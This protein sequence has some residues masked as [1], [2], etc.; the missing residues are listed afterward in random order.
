[1]PELKYLF[2]GSP[3]LAAT[4]LEAL[5]TRL[6]EPLAVVTQVAKAAGRGQKIQPTAVETYAKTQGLTVFSSLNVNHAHTMEILKTFQPDVILVAA[7]GQILKKEL[8]TLPRLFCLNVHASLLPKYRGAAPIQWAIWNGETETGITVQK[9]AQKLDT[10]DILLQHR[11]HI[12]PDETS[13]RLMDRLAVLGGECL[14]EAMQKIEAG[15]YAFTP[16]EESQATY[17]A[18]IEKAQAA[19]DWTQP[20][21]RLANQLRALQPWP[22]AETSLGGERLKVFAGHVKENGAGAPGSIF[23]DSKTYIA[24]TCGDKKAL[25]LTEIQLEN[26][27]KLDVKDFLKAYRG[28]FP[29]TRMGST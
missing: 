1:M 16:Q 26:R 14:V 13:G 3:P 7:F 21:S 10:G 8:L 28:Q 20:A 6:Y 22:V 24:V 9:M 2:M 12:E 23:T 17:A 15:Q 11:L 19:L 18:K 5:C 25:S 27:K 4:I 29:H